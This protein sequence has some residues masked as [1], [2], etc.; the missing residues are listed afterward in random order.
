MAIGTGKLTVS[1]IAQ[2]WSVLIA[3]AVEPARKTLSGLLIIE[4]DGTWKAS[5]EV[6]T[7]YETRETQDLET[8]VKWYNA[9]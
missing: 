9:E 5:F 4:K 6:Q 2:E 8:A 7:A 3:F 1:K